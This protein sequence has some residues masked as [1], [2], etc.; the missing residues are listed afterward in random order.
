MIFGPSTIEIDDFIQT[1]VSVTVG[2]NLLCASSL[3][4]NY[5][6]RAL[7]QRQQAPWPRNCHLRW[8]RSDGMHFSLL[9]CSLDITAL[10]AFV[11]VAITCL[12]LYFFNVY[13]HYLSLFH[14]LLIFFNFFTNNTKKE[15]KECLLFV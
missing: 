6:I 8:H 10:F 1:D 12:L 11:F 2:I 7:G 13:I 9:Q 15:N 4:P 5:W 14:I 3:L